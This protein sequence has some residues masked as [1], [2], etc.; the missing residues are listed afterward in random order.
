MYCWLVSGVNIQGVD[1]GGGIQQLDPLGV[2]IGARAHHQ[3]VMRPFSASG[4]VHV[5]ELLCIHVHLLPVYYLLRDLSHCSGP[6]ST[7]FPGG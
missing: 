2:V 5:M 7:S 6:T 3:D 1:L 4:N